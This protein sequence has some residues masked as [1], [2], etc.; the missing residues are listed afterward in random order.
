MPMHIKNWLVLKQ[1]FLVSAILI[2]CFITFISLK[3]NN[4]LPNISLVNIDKIFHVFAYVI[5][6][7]L[8]AIS[9]YFY[10]PQ[11]HFVKLL[12]IVVFALL[13]YGIIIEALQSRMTTTRLFELN[14]LLANLIGIVLGSA[15]YR[16]LVVPKLKN[17]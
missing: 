10:L 3:E 1:L 2:T 5:L 16:Y 11:M 14:D 6:T 13:C 12:A 17:N 15:I 7:L 4:E 9:L 8:W